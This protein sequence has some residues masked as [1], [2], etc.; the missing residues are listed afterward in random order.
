MEMLRG[1]RVTFHT[2]ECLEGLEEQVTAWLE[3]VGL[4]AASTAAEVA[5]HKTGALRNSISHSVE[6]AEHR[7]HVGTSGIDYAIYQELGTSRIAG[8]HF[9][10]FGATAHV[11][12]YQRLLEQ[13]LKQ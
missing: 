3:A 1:V 9:I 5:P 8:K 13:Y 7:V 2:D 4:D 11:N 10:E 12:D 6:P